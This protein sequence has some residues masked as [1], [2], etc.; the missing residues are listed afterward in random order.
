MVAAPLSLG[1]AG[2]R[3]R[4]MRPD[5]G[6]DLIGRSRVRPADPFPAPSPNTA[7]VDEPGGVE[8]LWTEGEERSSTAHEPYLM[9]RARRYRLM[10]TPVEEV[11]LSAQ[12]WL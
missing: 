5:R 3:G 9:S 6:A 4:S 1:L 2:S 10:T 11:V 8:A 12:R 7:S